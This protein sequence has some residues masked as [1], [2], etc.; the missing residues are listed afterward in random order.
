MHQPPPAT[1]CDACLVP[2][3]HVLISELYTHLHIY[4]NI[5]I[6]G[7]DASAMRHL[8]CKGQ[9]FLKKNRHARE[10]RGRRAGGVAGHGVQPLNLLLLCTYI[11]I[12]T[13]SYIYVYKYMYMYIYIYICM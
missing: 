10:R 9:S 4:T 12:H 3:N 13:C 11:Y 8:V 6:S 2:Q 7:D 5:P 1:I